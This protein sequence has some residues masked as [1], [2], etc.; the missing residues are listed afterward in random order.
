[1]STEALG[2]ESLCYGW[3]TKE[4]EMKWPEANAFAA[5]HRIFYGLERT[6]VQEVTRKS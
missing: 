5:L 3:E 4:R 6:Q 2:W 1:M